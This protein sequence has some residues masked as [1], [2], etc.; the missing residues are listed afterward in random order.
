MTISLP[1]V[2][3]RAADYCETASD[4][5]TK[6][7]GT[8]LRELLEHLRMV[9]AEPERLQEFFDLWSDRDPNPMAAADPQ[10]PDDGEERI[11]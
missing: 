11:A 9:R 7:L 2:L 1:G 4:W 5:P 6:G 10:P 8:S 3:N